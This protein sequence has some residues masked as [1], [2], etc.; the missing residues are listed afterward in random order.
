MQGWL[1]S[2]NYTYLG[3]AWVVWKPIREM[4]LREDGEVGALGSRRGDEGGG[5]EEVGFGVE[6]LIGQ[7]A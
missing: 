1:R 4:I 6:G 3:K 2:S 7:L 5:F